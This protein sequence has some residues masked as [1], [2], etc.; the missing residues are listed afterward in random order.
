MK[1]L[2]TGGAGY[3]GSHMVKYLIKKKCSVTVID[4]LSTGYRNAVKNCTFVQ[5]DLA[6]QQLIEEVLAETHFDAVFHFAAFSQVGESVVHPLKYFRNNVSN[7]ANLLHAMEQAKVRYLVYSS[8]AAVYGEPEGDSISESDP[9]SPINPYGRSK[10]VTENLIK[11]CSAASD[12]KAVCLRYFNAAGADPETELGECHEPETHLIPLLL[13]VA[14]GKQEKITVYGDDYETPDGTCIRDYIHVWDLCEAHWLGLKRIIQDSN[15]IRI[16][17]LGNGEGFSVYEV[18]RCSKEVTGQKIKSVLEK[19]RLGDP[20]RLVANA[21]LARKELG[22]RPKHSA[23]E[24]IIAD[25]WSWEKNNG[26]N[27]AGNK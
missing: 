4:N 27:T 21:S 14:S 3:I 18:I 1:V 15:K 25:A 11:D 22:W 6:D 5:G 7:T 2:V 8:S 24:Q 23:L 17:N 19:R 10:L 26:I 20:V 16:Y 9:T 13:Q 12:L